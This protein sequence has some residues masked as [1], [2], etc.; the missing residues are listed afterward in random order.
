MNLVKF[1]TYDAVNSILSS[2]GDLVG[3]VTGGGVTVARGGG[4]TSVRFALLVDATWVEA[5][6]MGGAALLL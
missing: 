4:A 6:A 1:F 3:G 2:W 5:E